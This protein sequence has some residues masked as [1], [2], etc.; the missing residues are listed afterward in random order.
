[1]TRRFPVVTHLESYRVAAAGLPAQAER[2]DRVAGAVVV[3][4][5]AT[6]WWDAAGLA[7]D[8]GASAVLVAEPREVPITEV[9]RLAEQSD[10]PILVARSRLRE[11]LVEVALE[12]RDGV[13]PRVV[14]AECR[15]PGAERAGMV[16]DA[17]GWT[18]ALAGVSLVVASAS[19][20][21]GGGAALLRART[22]GAVVGSMIVTT[23][24]P[25][26]MLVRVQ[27][28]GEV[29]TEFELDEPMGRTELATSTSRGRCV[30][31]ARVEAAE[32][33]ALRRA[34]AV[35]AQSVTTPDL[36][37]LLHD[38]ETATAILRSAAG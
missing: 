27:A 25:E 10:V 38:A 2:S 6:E 31:P 23:T 20:V 36:A 34:L 12:Q 21:S 22:G 7:I 1:M 15:A 29:V 5:G 24:Q 32:R 16:R 26:G 33:V 37:H 28:L 9:G 14:V 4:D 8:A 35:V 3:V 19:F 11:D 17:V 30:A 13:A 18:R